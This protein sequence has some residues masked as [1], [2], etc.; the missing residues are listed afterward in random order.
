MFWFI[1]AF[2][3]WWFNQIVRIV[4]F[5]IHSLTGWWVP[6]SGVRYTMV[7]K[8]IDYLNHVKKGCDR[9]NAIFLHQLSQQV[10]TLYA[11]DRFIYGFRNSSSS[12]LNIVK[13][14]TVG[15][16]WPVATSFV[17][18]H[19]L[20][21]FSHWLMIWKELRRLTFL[22]E[23]IVYTRP[24]GKWKCRYILSR[25]ENRCSE[26]KSSLELRLL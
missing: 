24:T 9:E 6:S 17:N 19:V 7:R 11:F 2:S 12:G 14:R 3:A 23:E 5:L 20:D 8:N 18:C 26:T 25:Y 21:T 4:Y 10:P 16:H 15:C 22:A 13:W 1:A